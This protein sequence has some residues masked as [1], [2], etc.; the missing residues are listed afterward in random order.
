MHYFRDDMVTDGIPLISLVLKSVVPVVNAREF[1][2]ILLQ[3][4]LTVCVLARFCW[5]SVGTGGGKRR[6]FRPQCLQFTN[7]T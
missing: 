2:D 6:C 3:A 7:N 4:A 1:W 5:A